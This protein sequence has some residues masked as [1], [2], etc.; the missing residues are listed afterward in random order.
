[1]RTS[2]YTWGG[3][4]LISV[5]LWMSSL[6][7]Q[8]NG[9]V[10]L[11]LLL[12]LGEESA[13]LFQWAG[14]CTDEDENIY[15]TDMMDN[16]IKKFSPQG[17]L[18]ASK[19]LPST[20]GANAKAIRLIGYRENHLY[21][22]DQNKAG[23]LRFDSNLNY[24]G[25]IAYAKPVADFSVHNSNLIH[26]TPV[27]MSGMMK[28]D[29][30]DSTG[31][32]QKSYSM[33]SEGKGGMHDMFSFTQDYLGDWYVCYRFKDRVAR[34]T[35][36]GEEVW[37]TQLYPG[38]K[39]VTE[40]ILFFEVPKTV[41]Y[42]DAAFDSH[43]H[44]FLLLGHLARNPNR[45]ILVMDR[46]GQIISQLTLDDTSHLLHIDRNDNLYVR[47]QKGTVLKKYKILDKSP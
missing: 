2:A 27:T 23:L 15:V 21:V 28:I 30:I 25:S 26:V 11:E 17:D 46:S 31:K 9:T 22:T 44:L 42:L 1:M 13:E 36:T 43:D 33:A 16:S 40:K 34:I 39:T 5:F 6:I 8:T 45:D 32:V 24:R 19:S 35:P 12:T 7:G 18:I 38:K 20:D 3:R 37:K 4:A 14:V 47:A 10:T 41:F 29:A